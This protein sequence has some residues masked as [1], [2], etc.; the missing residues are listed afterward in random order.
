MYH[1]GEDLSTPIIGR[2]LTLFQTFHL[3]GNRC[4]VAVILQCLRSSVP[5]VI[6]T[7]ENGRFLHRGWVTVVLL[8]LDYPVLLEPHPF[9]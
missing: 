4:G 9:A 2:L 1:F 7:E 5:A 6:I 3:T 8:V